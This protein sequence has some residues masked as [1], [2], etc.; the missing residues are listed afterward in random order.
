MRPWSDGLAE[1]VNKTLLNMLNCV[2]LGNPFSWD[3]LIRLCCLAFNTSCHSSVSET[4]AMM[5]FGREFTLPVDLAMPFEQVDQNVCQTAPEYVLNLQ[6]RL[7]DIH[8]KARESQKMATMKQQ[9]HYNNRLK[10]NEYHVGSLVYYHF[11]IKGNASK[12]SFYKWKGPYAVVEKI[13]DCI[14]KI[15]M[16]ARSHPLIVNHDRLKPAQ[17]REPVDTSW[18]SKIPI[19]N[20]TELSPDAAEEQIKSDSADNRPKRTVKKPNRYGDWHYE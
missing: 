11:P 3:T 2:V 20:Q 8:S 7:H 4:P 10:Q 5:M 14:Y 12:E 19:Y 18:V 9:K 17:T 13:S 16:S 1:N 6:S 15:Q